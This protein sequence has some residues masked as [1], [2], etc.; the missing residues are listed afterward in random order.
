MNIGSWHR[1]YREPEGREPFR[2]DGE[3]LRRYMEWLCR[4]R[5][6]RE[7]GTLTAGERPGSGCWEF[8]NRVRLKKINQDPIVPD[9]NFN[10]DHDRCEKFLI[11]VWLKI[12]KSK[13]AENFSIRV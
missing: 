4:G 3:N 11:K 2:A 9:H 1:V 5:M 13:S 6:V 12:K 7:V 10:R 8:S